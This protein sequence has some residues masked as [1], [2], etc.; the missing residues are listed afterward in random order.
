MGIPHL[1]K[2]G[3]LGQV[4]RFSTVDGREYRRGDDVVC[5]TDRGLEIGSVLCPLDQTGAPQNLDGQMLRQVTPDD[6]LIM[7]RINRFRDRAFSACNQLL[8]ERK[9]AAVLVDVEH[10]F[11]G[12]SL[13]FYFL[14]DVPEQVH[15]LTDELAAVYEKKVRFRKFTETLASGCG[16]DC[17]TGE[18]KCSSGGCGSC[19]MSGTCK[20]AGREESFRVAD[21]EFHCCD[22]ELTFESVPDGTGYAQ[23]EC[24]QCQQIC[25]TAEFEGKSTKALESSQRFIIIAEFADEGS[26]EPLTEKLEAAGIPVQINLP[27]VTEGDFFMGGSDNVCVLVPA[28]FAERARQVIES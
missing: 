15:N 12:Q 27:D 18:S 19:A 2:I 6:R 28:N 11:D 25:M 26:A 14:G 1:V 9:L 24:P 8:N 13:F 20:T 3:L 23:S 4:G 17:G 21:L 5:R 16:P 10:L 7:N 22:C